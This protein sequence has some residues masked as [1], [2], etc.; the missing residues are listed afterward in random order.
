M[1]SSSVST[2]SGYG[3]ASRFPAPDEFAPPKVKESDKYGLQYA[4][5]AYF[6]T[7]RYGYR[8]FNDVTN[9]NALMELAQGRQSVEPIYRMLGFFNDQG[10]TQ[11]DNQS[12][13][14]IDV[15]VLNLVT[16]YVNRTVAKIQRTGR[17]NINFTAVDPLSVNEAK[18]HDAKIKT[19]YQMKDWFKDMKLD[20]Q[21]FFPEMDLSVLPEYPEKLLLNLSVNPKIKKIMDAEKTMKLL[22]N[23]I[24]D[25]GQIMRECDWY[26]AV[27][28]RQHVHCYLDENNIPRA[29]AINPK[30]WGGSY[31]ENE[32][33]S[34]QEYAFFIDFITRNQFKK[35]AEGLLSKS[36]MESIISAHAFPNTAASFG[37]L[38]QYYDNYDGLEYIPVMRFYFLSN[39]NV[40]WKIWNNQDTGNRM[41]DQTHYNYFPTENSNKDQKV[42]QNSWTNVYGGTWIIDSE[43]VYGYGRKKMPHTNLVNARLPII[44]FAPNMKEGRLVS[45]CSQMVEPAFMLN[46]AWNRLKDILAK[47]RMG[48]LELNL[49]AIDNIGLGQGGAKWTEKQVIDFFMQSQLLVTRQVTTPFGQS[50]GQAIR[51]LNSGLTIQDYSTVISACIKFMDELSGSSVVE[52]STLPDRLTTGAMK[53]NIDASNDAIEYLINGHRQVYK[54]SCHVLMLLAQQAKMDKTKIVGMIPALGTSTTEY[55][56]VPDEIAY[57]DYGLQMQPEP[58]EEEWIEFYGELIES[59]KLGRLNSSDSAFIRQIKDMTMARQVMANR[60]KINEAKAMKMRQQDQQF[61]MQAGA[62]AGKQKLEIEMQLLDKKKQDDMELM[63]VQAR[64]DDMLMQRKILLESEANKT[65]DMVK[66]QIARQQGIDSV[67]KEAMR[68]RSE[69]KKTDAHKEVGLVSA[70]VQNAKTAIDAHVKMTVSKNKPQPKK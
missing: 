24:N 26:S 57:C 3:S 11:S 18:N 25:M 33:F 19:L 39:D 53:S 68:S 50:M 61:Q 63:Q 41:Y 27:I 23:T 22:N 17:Y 42:V 32:D 54:E 69:D 48:P 52:S 5:A 9:Y 13:A 40:A 67:L 64:I 14:Y 16:K 51:E 46:V 28:G 29:K 37:T 4:K 6:A 47:G 65:S 66:S 12:L 30:F 56:E 38:P 45:M 58:T 55:F 62:Q 35:E 70:Q 36:E 34:K 1:A 20:P 8:L 15:Q 59:V 10:Q 7:N 49:T 2:V 31:V 60:E 44:T 43:T 21:Q